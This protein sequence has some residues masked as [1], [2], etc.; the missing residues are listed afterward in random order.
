M[1]NQADHIISRLRLPPD[2]RDRIAESAKTHNRSMNAD[3]VAR[4]EQTFAIPTEV[5]SLEA[6][7]KEYLSNKV[8]NLNYHLGCLEGKISACEYIIHAIRNGTGKKYDNDTEM[9]NELFKFG[10]ILDQATTEKTHIERKLQE[11]IQTLSA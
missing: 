4:L 11:V 5:S 3:M 7:R 8:N 10:V 6:A 1:S 2:L 9:Q